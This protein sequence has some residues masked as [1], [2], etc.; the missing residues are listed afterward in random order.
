[1]RWLTPSRSRGLAALGVVVG[2]GLM[3]G[4]ASAQTGPGSVRSR[5]PLSERRGGTPPGENKPATA[6]TEPAK[7]EA[8]PE[9]TEPKKDGFLGDTSKFTRYGGWGSMGAAMGQ[10][11]VARSMLVMMPPV[12]KEL[13]LTDEQKKE[14]RE[15]GEE[16]R[17]RGEK[18]GESMRKQGEDPFR[19]GN[20]EGGEEA[21]VLTRVNQFTGMMSR[22]TDLMRENDDE[23]NKVLNKA[24]RKRLDQIALQMEG[25]MALARPEVGEALGL[26]PVEQEEIAQIIARSRMTQMTA[27]VGTMMSMRNFRDRRPAPASNAKPDRNADQPKTDAEGK[28]A[29]DGKPNT[30]DAEA[31][32]QREKAM[33]ERFQALRTNNDKVQDQ[34]V[35]EILK[36]LNKSQRA[37]FTQML[38]PPFDPNQLTELGRPPGRPARPE[39]EKTPAR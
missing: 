34:A 11:G 24:Q 25:V 23:L 8:K 5:P 29:G 27:M 2:L 17:K 37:K 28:S 15:V 22:V 31:R 36:F 35:R 18:M 12:Q 19:N 30:A 21:S 39:P 14:L 10:F 38:G 33:R 7:A 9:A 1:M 26:F 16:T 4:L 32:A 13:K 20:A 6:P 3:P